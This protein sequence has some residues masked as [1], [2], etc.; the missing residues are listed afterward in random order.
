MHLS[1]YQHLSH[2]S[3]MN[4][5]CLHVRMYVHT[6]RCEYMKEYLNVYQ[7]VGMTTQR[8]GVHVSVHTWGHMDSWNSCGT[9][10]QQT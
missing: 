7:R 3:N 1:M 6:K 9:Q 10:C 4:S 8:A 2:P 5:V